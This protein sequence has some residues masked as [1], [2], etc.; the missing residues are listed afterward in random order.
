MSW[1]TSSPGVSGA[2]AGVLTVLD[3]GEIFARQLTAEELRM[4]RID[5]TRSFGEIRV[6]LLVTGKDGEL[7]E[8]AHYA[9]HNLPPLLGRS[10]E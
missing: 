6:R 10:S 5:Y 9:P 7:V 4:G 1:D 2:S 3:Q 8:E